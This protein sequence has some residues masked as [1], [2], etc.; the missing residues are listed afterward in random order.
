M[1]FEWL[2]SPITLCALMATVLICALVLFIS[3]KCEIEST[4]QL[5]RKSSEAAD[6]LKSSLSAELAAVRESIPPVIETN[7]PAAE[8]LNLNRRAAAL[9]MD[10]R[11]ETVASI[12]AALRVPQNEIELILKLQKLAG[13]ADLHTA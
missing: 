4:R 11:G 7:A 12:A 8:G 1:H 3:L 6:Q 10:R 2:A 13:Q 9:R 5:A